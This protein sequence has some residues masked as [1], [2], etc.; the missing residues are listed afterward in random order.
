[1]SQF[2][3]PEKSMGWSGM[4][5]WGKNCDNRARKVW[6]QSIILQSSLKNLRISGAG[7]V[8][9]LWKDRVVTFTKEN[10]QFVTFYKYPMILLPNFIIVLI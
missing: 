9:Q 5:V 4:Y 7:M 6:K 8:N 3:K 2:R 10:I 1:M